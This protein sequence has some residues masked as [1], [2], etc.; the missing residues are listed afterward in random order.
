MKNRTSNFFRSVSSYLIDHALEIIVG[1]PIITGYVK[2]V[3]YR[4]TNIL[5]SMTRTEVILLMCCC[6]SV[7]T[8]VILVIAL[9]KSWKNSQNHLPNKV[10]NVFNMNRIR[11][12]TPEN[13]SRQ[14]FSIA[15]CIQHFYYILDCKPAQ[16]LIVGVWMVEILAR[17]EIASSDMSFKLHTYHS[18]FFMAEIAKECGLLQRQY[19][20]SCLIVVLY[21][22]E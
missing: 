16:N 1:L 10:R 8:C 7:I 3:A 4:I 19:F 12:I 20:K 17:Q 15:V 2:Y 5:K 18:Q 14:V 9:H 22:L 13:D 21:S 11:T 6:V